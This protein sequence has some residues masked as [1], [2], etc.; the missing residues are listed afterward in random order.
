MPVSYWLGYLVHVKVPLDDV[1]LMC[2]ICNHDNFEQTFCLKIVS[3]LELVADLWTHLLPIVLPSWGENVCQAVYGKNEQRKFDVNDPRFTGV[4]LD[5]N[6]LVCSIVLINCSINCSEG[7]GC[8][9]RFL[10]S[11]WLFL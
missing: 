11:M 6:P 7:G 1:C 3:C 2:F 5:E 8:D 10:V 9:K 4:P